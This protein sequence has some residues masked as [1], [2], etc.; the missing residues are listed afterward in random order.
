MSELPRLR[1][2]LSHSD[3]FTALDGADALAVEALLRD[4]AYR[5]IPPTLLAGWSANAVP[6]LR[7]AG[8]PVTFV[9]LVPG[10]AEW[11]VA[12]RDDYMLQQ[13]QLINPNYTVSAATIP[14]CEMCTATKHCDS[15]CKDIM[16]ATGQPLTVDVN[17]AGVIYTAKLVFSL[18]WESEQ[19]D[20]EA[21]GQAA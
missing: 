19:V 3:N 17:H 7:L 2:L 6:M 5:T 18:E 9:K 20:D 15:R 1:L 16:M 4:A 11:T 13:A 21:G 10:A 14:Y 8:P 12:N